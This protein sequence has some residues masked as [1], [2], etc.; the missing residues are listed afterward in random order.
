M[1]VTRA[2]RNPAMDLPEVPSEAVKREL[3]WRRR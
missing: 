3:A 2:Q 1:N